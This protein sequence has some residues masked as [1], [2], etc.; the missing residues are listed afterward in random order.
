MHGK[1]KDVKSNKENKYLLF[2]KQIKYW[3]SIAQT[4]IFRDI[5]GSLNLVGRGGRWHRRHMVWLG[6]AD[7]TPTT[8]EIP[9]K[10]Y[11][12]NGRPGPSHQLKSPSLKWCSIN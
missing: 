5:T 12:V 9:P 1:T 3:L 2:Y 10:K 6:L 11:L 4:C 7:I 8:A